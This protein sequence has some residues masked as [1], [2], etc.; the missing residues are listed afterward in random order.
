MC[1]IRHVFVPKASQCG[2]VDAHP[3]TASNLA[4]RLVALVLSVSGVTHASPSPVP[5]DPAAVVPATAQTVKTA[6][7]TDWVPYEKTGDNDAYCDGKY[8][9][10]PGF[11]A[12]PRSGPQP[13]ELDANSALHVNEHSTTL[14]GNVQ[15]DQPGRRLTAPFLT[16]D[17][18]S[19]YTHI[20]GPLTLRES[21]ILITGD[22][23]DGN[24]LAGTGVIDNATFL[25]HEA[26]FRGRAGELRREDSG[27]LVIKDSHFTRCD[28]GSNSWSIRGRDVVLAPETGFGTARNVTIAIKDVPILYLPYLRFPIDDERHTGFL[29]PS[30]SVDDDSGV[31]LATPYYLNL[32]P[33]LDATVIPR[34]LWK[35]G[36]HME[37][38]LRYRSVRTNNEVNIGY[39]PRDKRFDDRER[40]DRSIGQTGM[41]DTFER[42][43]RW[44][45]NIRHTGDWS[46]TLQSQLR[47]NAASDTDYLHDFGGP[48]DSA[49]VGR[50]LSSVDTSAGNERSAALERFGRLSYT[51]DDWRASIEV[52]RFQT[53][54]PLGTEQYRRLPTLRLANNRNLRRV[55]I[56][57]EAEFSSFDKPGAVS[58]N[59]SNLRIDARLP[60]R[61]RWGFLVPSIFASHRTYD[62]NGTPNDRPRYT[63][64]GAALDSGLIFDR[65][66]SIRGRPLQ[67]TL[68]PR[69]YFL[70]VERADQ[71]GAPLFDTNVSTSSLAQLFRTNQF[72]GADRINDA[73]QVT[74]AVTT[75]LIQPETGRQLATLALAQVQYARERTV[76][77]NRFDNRT[78]RS[79]IFAEAGISPHPFWQVRANLVWEPETGRTHNGGFTLRY[80]KNDDR[81]FNLSYRLNEVARSQFET[82]EQSDVSFIWPIKGRWSAIGRWNFGW[83]RNKT[84][85]SFYGFEY[86]D[87]CWKTRL[88]VRKIRLRPRLRTI[89]DDDPT[90]PGQLMTSTFL[91]ER[92][93]TGIFFEFQLKGLASAG[94]RVDALLDETIFG[95]RAREDRIAR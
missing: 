58:G 49:S 65:F 94:R 14:V 64:P 29:M 11:D 23:A 15:A 70:Y 83:D 1:F 27:H 75:Q 85:E 42:Q 22:A 36:L 95:Y 55:A 92:S 12:A 35:R 86:N 71:T 89:V 4:A 19:N 69:A 9:A 91:D 24:L 3:G 30:L 33:N 48:V 25:L 93:D 17:D 90:S 88:V 51:R 37:G 38:Q 44:L 59:R 53:L 78:S 16:I 67:Q 79:P 34:S 81:L 73:G 62:L 10:P 54:D 20:E 50:F 26:R 56:A 87:C 6:A 7:E 28:P 32:A 52:Q 13:L 45:A 41:G 57:S 80:N 8:I 21:G 43:D 5:R 76:N 40:I 61:K 18:A 84:I 68:E 2:A 77:A 72:V 31:D 63:I 46:P 74:L 82:L 60:T 66:F 39:L 47:Y